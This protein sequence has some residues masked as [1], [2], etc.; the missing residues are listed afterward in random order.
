MTQLSLLGTTEMYTSFWFQVRVNEEAAPDSHC[1]TLENSTILDAGTYARLCWQLTHVH[2]SYHT[3]DA[4]RT[5]DIMV[6]QP[7]TLLW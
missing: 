2:T 6:A 3:F 4:R 5:D 7:K 1:M